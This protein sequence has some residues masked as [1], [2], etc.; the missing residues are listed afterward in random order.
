M[1]TSYLKDASF[2]KTDLS[3]ERCEHPWSC[4]LR[5]S[6]A[7]FTERTR[8]SA[9]RERSWVWRVANQT[10]PQVAADSRHWG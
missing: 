5:F 9:E 1:D 2:D 6:G 3:S 10:G 8:T 7:G 4:V